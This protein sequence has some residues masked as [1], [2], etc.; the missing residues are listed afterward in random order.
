[1]SGA[2]LADL[3]AR[4]QE[5]AGLLRDPDLD[6]GRAEELAREAGDLAAKVGAEAERALQQPRTEDE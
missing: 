6:D 3:A 1:M 4:L 5:L 2:E